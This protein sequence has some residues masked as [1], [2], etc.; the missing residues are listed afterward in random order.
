V[1]PAAGRN[2]RE[3]HRISAVILLSNGRTVADVADALLFDPETVRA[4]YKRYKGGGREFVAHER[5]RQ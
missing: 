3:S 5:C 2:V 1:R 4:H